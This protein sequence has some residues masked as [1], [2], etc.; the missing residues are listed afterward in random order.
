MVEKE[1]ETAQSPRKIN[2]V[3]DKGGN[4]SMFGLKDMAL[5][6]VVAMKRP[7][8]LEETAAEGIAPRYRL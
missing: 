7:E 2:R 8:E 3:E 6:L 5:Y 4:L 1:R